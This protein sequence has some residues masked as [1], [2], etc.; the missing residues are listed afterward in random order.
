MAE[1]RLV[2]FCNKNNVHV[3]A[4][5]PLGSPSYVSIGMGKGA[6]SLLEHDAIKAIAAKHGATPG[7]V[8]LKWGVARGTSIIPKSSKPARIEENLACVEVPLDAEDI[9]EINK[10]NC[11]L[12]FNE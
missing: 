5:S 7:Q 2:A 11:G 10:L 4:F 8:L 3:T 6:L 9:A 12:R 1:E